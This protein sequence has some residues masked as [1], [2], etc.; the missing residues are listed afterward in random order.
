M[1]T[2]SSMTHALTSGWERVALV[3]EKVRERL[4]RVASA[5][6]QAGVPYAVAGGNA[7]AE[8]VGRVDPAAVRNTQDVNILIRRS[9]L[10]AVKDALAA[11]GFLYDQVAGVDLFLDGVR[12]TS[13]DAA[14]VVFATEKVR[15]QYSFPAPDV[16]ESVS[17]AMFRVLSLEALIR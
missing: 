6:E 8:W 4:R 7:V 10:E 16:I 15:P 17:G 5:L 9:D 11:A 3:V 14:H 1:D 12:T 13:R 2:I